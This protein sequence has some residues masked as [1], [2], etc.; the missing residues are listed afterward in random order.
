MEGLPRSFDF[1]LSEIGL[2]HF[3]EKSYADALPFF[4]QALALNPS[5][6]NSRLQSYYFDYARSLFFG[7]T[8]KDWNNAIEQLDRAMEITPEKPQ[9]Y[10]WKGNCLEK[11]GNCNEAIACLTLA[12]DNRTNALT[13][14]ERC[15][16]LVTRTGCYNTLGMKEK[17]DRDS[18]E[19]NRLMKL[20]VIAG[21]NYL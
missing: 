3:M 15:R 18:A 17:A 10:V 21:D 14:A 13:D 1:Y 5:G 6:L 12:L 8:T 19:S 11:L 7:G 9:P 16:A 4:E 20:P 2:T